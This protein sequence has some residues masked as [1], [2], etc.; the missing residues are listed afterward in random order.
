MVHTHKLNLQSYMVFPPSIVMLYDGI[1]V[2]CSDVFPVENLL[3]PPLIICN[4][5]GKSQSWSELT[6]D[7]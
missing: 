5:F 3:I 7:M 6:G 2:C 4:K 1:T